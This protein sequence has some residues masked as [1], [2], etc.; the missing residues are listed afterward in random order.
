MRP[1]KKGKTRGRKPPKKREN[2]LTPFYERFTE[3]KIEEWKKQFKG[4]ELIFI[5]VEHFLAVLR[6]PTVEDIANYLTLVT[7]ENMSKAVSALLQDL[8][9]DGDYDLIEDEDNFIAVFFQINTLME[10]KKSEFFRA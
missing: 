7:G 4:R 2:D 5:R 1:E 8:W 6:P 9:L 10:G 3:G